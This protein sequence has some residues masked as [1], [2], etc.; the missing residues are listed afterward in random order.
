M[1]KEKKILAVDVGG[2]SLKMAE[3]IF[4]AAGG[5]Q[6]TGFRF[7]RVDKLDG[8]SDGACFERNYLEMLGEGG[9]TATEVR[10]LLSAGNSFQRLSKLPPMLGSS[11]TVSRLI[12]FEASQAVPYSMDEVEWG[13]QLLHHR[14]EETRAVEQEDG[15]VENISVANEEYEALFVAM[16]SEDVVCYTDVIENAGQKLLSVELAPLALFNA[17]VVSQIREDECVLVLDIG[18]RTSSLMIADRR[19]IFMRN[20]PLGGD[21]VT[22]QIAREFGVPESEAE[23]LKRRVGFVALGGA[24][25]E[26]DSELAATI[27]KLARNA[28]T[29]L[30]G[31]ISRSVSVWRAQHGGDAPTRV[32]LAGGGSTMQY[33]TDFF[34]EKLRLPVEYLNTFG[35]IGINPSV[36]LAALQNVASMS[37]SLIGAALRNIGTLPVDISLLPRSIRKQVELNARKPYFYASAAALVC[38]LIV[39][40]VGVSKELDFEKKRV[41]RVEEDVRRA[42][43]EVKKINAVAG[44]L[45]SWRGQYDES[46][47]FLRDRGKFTD[48]LNAIQEM[49]PDRM[50]L[51]SLEPAVQSGENNGG[52]EAEP[53]R[54]DEKR[55]KHQTPESVNALRE[56]RNI[57]LTGYTLNLDENRNLFDEF[58]SRVRKSGLF[59]PN[60]QVPRL[61]IARN[62]NLTYFEVILPLKEA[63]R[64]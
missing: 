39:S 45:N 50:W 63:L 53:G 32:L 26:P 15:T 55:E 2:S 31:E 7:R 42:D 44:E 21:T 52:D 33:T 24:Y 9:F 64:K 54:R 46:A 6:L 43:G 30:H 23:D 47:Q 13:Y 48:V 56:V 58:I 62:S 20:I 19:R 28:M 37:Q 59:E 11:A 38:C 8:E 51:V 57:A 29:R 4:P 36:D 10:L 1:A 12:E 61:E 17:A 25:D 16:K 60:L 40:A 27:S 41:A 35:L 14:W 5:I 3:F 34:Q 18:S 49:M 22:A